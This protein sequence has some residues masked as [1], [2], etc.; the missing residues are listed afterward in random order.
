MLAVKPESSPATAPK[1]LFRS[2]LIRLRL[3]LS[4]HSFIMFNVIDTRSNKVAGIA[5]TYKEAKAMASAYRRSQYIKKEN[6]Q[7]I[8]IKK[9][10][11]PPVRTYFAT[12]D[13]C[14]DSLRDRNCEIY[15][16]AHR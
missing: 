8:A 12:D 4:P 7:V 14:C 1:L 3:A 15:G 2:N 9:R 6:W 16:R 10:I 5:Y 13:G 11:E